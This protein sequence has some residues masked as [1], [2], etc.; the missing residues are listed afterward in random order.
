M[1][2]KPTRILEFFLTCLAPIGLPLLFH[3]ELD[4]FRTMD[5]HIMNNSI[6]L[7]E[8][9]ELTRITRAEEGFLFLG[10]LWMFRLVMEIQCMFLEKP[11]VA[12]LTHMAKLFL[13]AL[14]VIKHRGLI[15]FGGLTGGAHKETLF[16][17]RIGKHDSLRGCYRSCLH[18]VDFNF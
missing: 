8:R 4:F 11:L 1:I 14:H 10:P 9:R 18:V 17:L 3:D 12:D 6:S 2:H 5:A 15:L 16:I 13:M 7:G